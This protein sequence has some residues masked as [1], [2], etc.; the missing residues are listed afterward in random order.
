MVATALCTLPGVECPQQAVSW[1]KVECVV[2]GMESVGVASVQAPPPPLVTMSLSL[3]FLLNP[4][5][6]T[7]E[8][9]DDVI[10]RATV[11]MFSQLCKYIG[12]FQ[13]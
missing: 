13:L 9:S 7:N 3:T 5:T 4:K 1:C 2:G 12:Q 10:I 11:T 8:V 6:R